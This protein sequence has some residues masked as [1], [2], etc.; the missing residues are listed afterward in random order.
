MAVNGEAVRDVKPCSIN[1][2]T[3]G[4][5]AMKGDNVYLYV[6]WWHGSSISISD[7]NIDF[8]SGIILGTNTEIEIKR[9]RK[10]IILEKLPQISPD[11]YCPVI[12]L[13]LNQ[14][15]EMT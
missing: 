3:Y 8:S 11:P 5:S 6:H 9:K 14:Q 1:G 12:K 7:C 15:A 4:C 13:T 2:G 10:H